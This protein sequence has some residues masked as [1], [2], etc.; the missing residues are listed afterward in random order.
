MRFRRIYWVTEQFFKDGTSEVAGI[1]TS[2]HDL[3]ETGIAPYNAGDYK[4]G[5][6]ITLCELDCA[7]P[8]LYSFKAPDFAGV[9]KELEPLVENGE[10]SREEIA[11]LC[12]ALV[13]AASP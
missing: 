11:Q 4:H 3:V 6:R 2:V 5:F 7:C 8:P 1:F 9:E 12:K 13:G 10:L